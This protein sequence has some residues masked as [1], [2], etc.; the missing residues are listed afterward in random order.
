MA[1][2]KMSDA[3]IDEMAEMRER[4]LTY[5]QIGRRFGLSAQAIRWQCLRVGAD[6]PK[7]ANVKPSTQ[8]MVTMRNGHPVRRFTPEEDALLLSGKAE[9]RSNTEI[10][11]QLDRRPN[12]VLGR[13][14]TIGMNDDRAERKLPSVH[15][16]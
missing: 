6:H 3:Q 16:G 10:A 14:M 4:G 1:T 9:G 11:R 2:R 13:L 5:T 7:G 12:S 8:P 15:H